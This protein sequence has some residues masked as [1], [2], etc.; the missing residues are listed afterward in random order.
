[1]SNAMII[2]RLKSSTQSRSAPINGSSIKGKEARELIA[3]ALN[4]PEQEVVLWYAGS[5]VPPDQLISAYSEVEVERR[6]STR[7]G[8]PPSAF[9]KAQ[10]D[11]LQGVS[12]FIGLS[13][14]SSTSTAVGFDTP[15]AQTGPQS[16][17]DRIAAMNDAIG[18]E[19]GAGRNFATGG[20]GR[21]GYRGGGGG[22][23]GMMRDM[24]DRRPPAPNYVCH[25]CMKKG[26]YIE[27]CPMPRSEKGKALS[28]PVGIPESMLER[29][30]PSEL[31]KAGNTGQ[32]FITKNGILVRRKVD[33]QGTSAAGSTVQ[34][35]AEDVPPELKC[36]VCQKL[37]DKAVR[38]PCCKESGKSEVFFCSSCLDDVMKKGMESEDGPLCPGCD[39]PLLLDEV[40]ADE[41][42]RRKV[43]ALTA[44][45]RKRPREEEES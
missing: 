3:N 44:E 42:L 5:E 29:V 6:M 35:D 1:M 38:P 28:L 34:L 32:F 13:K 31:E 18:R 14:T 8:K 4:L 36:F 2:F 25:N 11:K 43:K 21:G 41:E 9:Q 27:D 24:S 19:M 16:E 40:V 26:H 45:S 17:E 15:V 23:G 37:V 30:D 33:V 7:L 12:D 39:E 20:G 22:R 10:K